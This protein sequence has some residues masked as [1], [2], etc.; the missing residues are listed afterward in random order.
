VTEAIDR[1]DEFF[2]EQRLEEYLAAHA[3]EPAEQLVQKL[4][5][6]MQHF[7]KGVRQADDITVLA[8]RYL[9]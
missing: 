9:G 2:G 5:L 3:S 7:S 4:H 6:T 1:N 8:L